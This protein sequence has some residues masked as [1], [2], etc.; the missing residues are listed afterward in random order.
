MI[1]LLLDNLVANRIPR[2]GFAITPVPFRRSPEPD[3]LIAACRHRGA[4]GTIPEP[5]CQVEL[6]D[7][8]L[9]RPFLARPFSI[10]NLRLGAAVS[11]ERDDLLLQFIRQAKEPRSEV[12]TD[13]YAAE[14]VYDH[15][16]R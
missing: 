2:S 4:Q 8:S 9:A 10:S 6:K 16:I 1:D 15:L 12:T 11:A 3:T 5:R 14:L 13:A 7:P